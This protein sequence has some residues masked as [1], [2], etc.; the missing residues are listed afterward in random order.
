[1]ARMA[2]ELGVELGPF[3]HWFNDETR[4]GREDG[5]FDSIEDNIRFV[6]EKMGVKATADCIHAAAGIRQEFVQSILIP[7]PDAIPTLKRLGAANLG[8]GLISDCSPEVPLLW[9]STELAP[10]FQIALFSSVEREMKPSPDLYLRACRALEVEP[11]HVLYIGDGGSFELTG[12]RQV[13]MLAVMIDPPDQRFGVEF[14]P[15]SADWDGP[16]IEQISDVLALV[17]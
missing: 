10:H 12:A 17:S 2:E 15:D 5:T 11:E 7:R 16:V 8:L 1:M 3:Y 14:R 9:P 6:L 13:G 4:I